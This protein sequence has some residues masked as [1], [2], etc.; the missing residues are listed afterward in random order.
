MFLP[1]IDRLRCIN[2][3]EDTWLIASIDVAEARDVLEGTLGCPVCHAEYR[4]HDG[5]VTFGDA[6]EPRDAVP[7]QDDALRVAAALDLTEP[8]RTAILHGGWG[9]HAAILRGISPAQL[10]LVNPP[11]GVSS[12]DGVSIVRAPVAPVA[13]A[14]ADGAAADGDA[15]GAMLESLCAALRARGR[16]LATAGTPTPAGFAELARDADVWVAERD[17]GAVASQPVALSRRTGRP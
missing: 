10:L 8:G 14:W 13:P 12:G 4:I 11:P 7:S 6:P 17:A 3:H 16:L 15:S 2:G 5:V 9:A 1:L